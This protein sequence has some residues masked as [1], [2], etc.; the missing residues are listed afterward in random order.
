MTNGHKISALRWLVKR[1][2]ELA[3]NAAAAGMAS[4]QD[5][6]SGRL[7]E[8]PADRADAPLV[9]DCGLLPTFHLSSSAHHR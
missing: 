4:W 9:A 1:S 7:G 6:G 2:R 5:G 3:A 8:T